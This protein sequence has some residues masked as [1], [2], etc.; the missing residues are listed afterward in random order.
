MTDDI[1]GLI[2]S[3]RPWLKIPK[4]LSVGQTD[5]LLIAAGNRTR[6]EWGAVE[7][8][9]RQAAQQEDALKDRTGAPQRSADAIETALRVRNAALL[10]FIY[11]TGARVSEACDLKT[12]WVYVKEGVARIEGKGNKQRVVPLGRSASAALSAYLSTARPVL[13][14]RNAPFVF[15]SRN[16][17]RLNRQQVFKLVKRFSE[18]AALPMNVSPH[19]LRHTCAT[20]LLE[21]GANL[22][23]VQEILGHADISTTEIYTHVNARR[24]V[25]THSKFHPRCG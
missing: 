16:G 17:W 13:D 1:G 9:A 5:K 20:H 14:C 4:S 12:E 18:S 10:M 24:L 6:A 23:A 2:Q 7:A 8:A 25:E 19:T 3:A 21:G 15:L 22:R 11:A